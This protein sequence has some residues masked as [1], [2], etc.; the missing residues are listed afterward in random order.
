MKRSTL[1]LPVDAGPIFAAATI[2]TAIL[3]ACGGERADTPRRLSVP[4]IQGAGHVSPHQG[5]LVRTTGVVTAVDSARFFLQDPAG[6]GDPATS[7]AVVVAAGD[8]DLP[9]TGDSVRVTGRVREFVPGGEESAGLSVTRIAADTVEGLA[10]G[11][12]LPGPV[13]LGTGGRIPP[14]EVVIS[15]DELPVDLAVPD[16]AAAA[17]FEADSEGID[18]YESLETMRVTVGAPVSISPT[19]RAGDGSVELWTLV[20]GGAHITPDDARTEAGGILLQPHPDNRG[21]QN[22]ERLQIRLGP[23]SNPRQGPPMLAVG[24]QL[25][26][27]TGVVGYRSGNYHVRLTEPVDFKPSGVL[28]GETSLRGG[29]DRIMVA[30]YNVLNLNPLPENEERMERIGRQIA[31]RLEAPDVVAL[32]EIQ[33]ENGTRGGEENRET[34]ATGTL[35]AL[36]EAVEAAGGAT[37]EFVDIAPEP[38]TSGGVS[39]GNIRNAF[40]YDPGRVERVDVT[41]LTPRVLREVGARDPEAF[42]GGRDPL[43]VT[44]SADGRRFTVVNNHFTSRAGSTPV[45]G[46]IHPFVQA[47]EEEREAQSRA[48]HDWVARRLEER[49]EVPVL[50]AGD[51]NTFEF[52]DDLTRILSGKGDDAIL[53]NLLRKVPADE[54]YT[55]IFEGNS[56]ALDHIFV[57]R[58]VADDAR[59]DVVHVNSIFSYRGRASSDHD[60]VVTSVPLR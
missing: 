31:E 12:P 28:P 2:A 42:D 1:R 57:S 15:D 19:E 11:A 50:V 8:A 29:P 3:L 16:E 47:G 7:D 44:F 36:A 26:D 59:G 10:T 17:D 33:D 5:H 22:P 35:R 9:S 24:S 39:G 13:R 38:N 20:D 37:Y 27:A 58:D 41:S 52:T 32:Q 4:E 14:Q 46:A 34:D 30:T 18:F 54:R 23:E 60:P 43:A 21:D 40:L 48:V 6:D 51:L 45:F 53:T 55:Y 25:G 56:Q 49:P